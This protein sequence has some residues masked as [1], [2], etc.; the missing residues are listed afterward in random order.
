MA[1]FTGSITRPE[2]RD[3]LL[4]SGYLLESR[5]ADVL[6][7]DYFFVE[8]NPVYPD[9]DTGKSREFDVSAMFAEP[10]GPVELDH[11]FGVLLIECVNNPQ[12]LA[13]LTVEPDL[14]HLHHYDI[15]MSGLPVKVIDKEDE[16][17]SW[18]LLADFLNLDKYHHYCNGRV[19]T[20]YCSFQKKSGQKDWMAF[21]DETHFD[22]LKKLC[23]VVEHEIEDHFCNWV[24]EEGTEERVNV[25]MYYP[26]LVLQGDLL[27]V[28]VRPRSMHIRKAQHLQYRRSLIRNG[29]QTTYQIDVITERFLKKYVEICRGEVEKAAK[30]M[31]RKGRVERIRES[32]DEIVKKAQKSKSRSELR[33]AMEF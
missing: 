19:A 13:L 10:A 20:Q 28:Q 5:V 24:F 18:L 23:D 3:A 7:E 29:E 33:K 2:I 25:Q 9:P 4:R 16:E 1:R 32:I 22:A 21:H 6:R 12:P 11:L 30:Y 14:P 27:D 17:A 8:G 26:L 31:R 15:K